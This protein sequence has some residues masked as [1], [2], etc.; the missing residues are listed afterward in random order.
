MSKGVY[1]TINDE[2]RAL[3]F[4]SLSNS[5]LCNIIEAKNIVVH[6]AKN[7]MAEK[8]QSGAK[9]LPKKNLHFFTV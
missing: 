6:E 4:D 2:R 8:C 5:V 9:Q 7:N 3:L 1:G